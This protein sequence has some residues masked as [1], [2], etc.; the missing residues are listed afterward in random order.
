MG[1]PLLLK[2]GKLRFC[3]AYDVQD[4]QHWLGVSLDCHSTYL[5]WNRRLSLNGQPSE[6]VI[7]LVTPVD[8]HQRN[9]RRK[10][11]LWPRQSGTCN[12]DLSSPCP[13]FRSGR[14]DT[15]RAYPD[16]VADP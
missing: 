15:P 12:L 16:V 10:L 6:R 5:A 13:R 3:N 2:A 9:G 8:L 1:F 14:V 7:A 11:V 4:V